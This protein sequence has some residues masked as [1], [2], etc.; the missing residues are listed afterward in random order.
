MFATNKDIR[1]SL[2]IS[3]V[4]GHRKSTHSLPSLIKQIR[5]DIATVIAMI[6]LYDLS[7]CADLFEDP[8]ST[9]AIGAI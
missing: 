6:E 4:A 2:H 9:I 5:L 8:F 1:N 3:F 7:I